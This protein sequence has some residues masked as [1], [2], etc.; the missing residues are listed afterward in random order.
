[1][2]WSSSYHFSPI[3]SNDP[4]HATFHP[5]Y[6]AGWDR[7]KPFLPTCLDH[8]CIYTHIYI[9]I[10]SICKET[11]RNPYAIYHIH[12]NIHVI[13]KPLI[14]YIYTPYIT[15]W[16]NMYKPYLLNTYINHMYIYIY[17]YSLSIYIY[18]ICIIYIY[19]H[20]MYYLYSICIY[21][22]I[23][24]AYVEKP[25]ETHMPYIININKYYIYMYSI[26]RETH[27]PYIIYTIIYTS[28]VNH[29]IYTIYLQTVWTIFF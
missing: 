7:L 10:H 20:N 2:G 8:V 27:M 29:C 21:I 1:M 25:W 24:T 5:R 18:T 17:H 12:G 28:F 13:C 16:Y 6:W 19:I 4:L 9:Y 23:C 15:K 14:K 26:C 22:Y 11:M 3:W